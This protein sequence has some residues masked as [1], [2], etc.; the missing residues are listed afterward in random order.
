MTNSSSPLEQLH[1]AIEKENPFNKE[2]VV[3]KQNVWKKE[4]PHVTSINANASDA[5]FK[6]IEEVR[7]GERQVIGITIKANKG[8]GKTHLLSRVRHQLQADGSA[9]FVYMTDYNDLNRIKPEF[10]K[11]LALSLK[12]VGSQGVTQWQELGTALAN[13]AMKRSYTS[14][15]LVNVFPNALAKNPK[16]IEQLTDKVLEIKSDIDNP[17]LIKGIFWTLS[18]Q[19]ALYAINWLSG[20]S[21]SQKKADELE[22]PNDS[23]DD[24][25]HFD[26][27]CHI[28]DLI[29]DYNPLV[30]CFDQLD[31]TECDDAG[32]S[33]AQVI[34]SLATDLYN[35]L[36]R[37]VLLTAMFPETWT[38]Q[39][40]ALE[41]NDAV[42]DRIGEREVELKPL[43]SDQIIDLVSLRL[44][45][46]YADNKLTPPQ[47]FYPFREET[48]KE[49]GKQRPTAR[50]VLKWCQTNWGLL[51]GQQVS[52]HRPTINPVS[53]AYNNEIKN[54]DNIDNEE[55]ME[56][57][58][59]LTNAIKFGLNQLIGQIVA[60]V[61]IE[62]IEA[63]VKPKNKYLGVKIVGKQEGNTVKIGLAVIQASVGNRVTAGLSH[64]GDYKKYDLTRGCL[65]RSKD[66]SPNA[67][68]AQEC[69]NNLKAQAGKWVVL[70]TEEVKPLIA[71]R[72]V[73]ESREDYELSEEQI[74]DFI[75]NTKLAIDNRLLRE[76]LSA[77]SGQITEE[78]VD[79]EA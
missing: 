77:P 57:D 1:N 25:D 23:E 52:S 28:L 59:Q 66:I 37:G 58:S 2:P 5:V 39:I 6:A 50:D 14:Q 51:N 17:Y 49:L 26:I 67:K 18:K 19:H 29:S 72:A 42:V 70:K 56:D 30:V 65:V 76:I 61:T 10:L 55:Y 12:E 11:T 4:L 73:Y 24:K 75:A 71:I 40:R 46:F 22:L 44:K 48:L 74:K 3:K 16:L 27:I 78:A 62:K 38:H 13:E 68:K 9:W 53:S 41:L 34:A 54:I 47:G 21:L 20:K 8:L 36:K 45:G 33:R 7:S 63:P 32:F 79:E 64:L 35:S 60:G 43:N 15:Q 31:G 69:W